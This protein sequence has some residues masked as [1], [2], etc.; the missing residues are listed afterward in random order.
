MQSVTLGIDQLLASRHLTGQRLGLVTNDAAR[1]ARDSI[2][3]SRVALQQAGLNLVR[4]FSPEHGLGATAADGLPVADDCDPLTGLP[5]VSL[6]GE[7][8]LPARETLADLEA[9]LL[10]LP[11]IGARFYTYV[12]TMSYML[13]ACAKTGVPLVILDR[14]N[15]LGGDLAAVEGP[16]LDTEHFSSFVGRAAIPI[17]HS[18]TMGE[19]G[20][21]LN[22][23]WNLN[24]KFDVISCAGWKRSM[25]WPD[26]GL[27]FVPTSPAIPSYES[28]L[29]YPGL[30]L[31]EATNL[32][33]GRGTELPFQVVGA[34]WLDPHAV[35]QSH[36]SHRF[37]GLV[38]EEIGFTPKQNPFAGLR[39]HGIRLRIVKDAC[40][41]P[42]ASGLDLLAAVIARHRPEFRWVNY[43]TA[44][45]P[46]GEQHFE[47]LIGRAGIREVLER[48]QPELA[49]Q[50]GK[51]IAA[52]GWVNR[53]KDF[54]LYS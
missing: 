38:A 37:L 41:R 48:N 33:V 40:V 2:V 31:F 7:H 26:T 43:P 9:V 16:M 12:W 50:I 30:C 54:L 8:L 25:R 11:D 4:L 47:R 6:Y 23:E 49:E 51:W 34:P 45:N 52:P 14:P 42:V 27:P 36:N 53:T 15:P 32:S 39:C 35:A 44:A 10:D 46:G 19:L 13:E 29:L 18:L 21:L 1:T 3:R 5:V 20:R 17:R 22:A 28:A 24:A